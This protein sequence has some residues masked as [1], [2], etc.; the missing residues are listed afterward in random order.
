MY[1]LYFFAHCYLLFTVAFIFLSVINSF[2][3]KD[4]IIK[5]IKKQKKYNKIKHKKNNHKKRLHQRRIKI[6]KP[7]IMSC[8]MVNNSYNIVIDEEI[9]FHDLQ[10]DASI[11]S[12]YQILKI[13][14]LKHYGKNRTAYLKF[15]Y[16]NGFVIIYTSLLK[17][18]DIDHY[19]YQDSFEIIST[20]RSNLN[21]ILKYFTQFIYQEPKIKQPIKYKSSYS[22]LLKKNITYLGKILPKEKSGI[23]LSSV[24]YLKNLNI[25]HYRHRYATIQIFHTFNTNKLIFTIKTFDIQNIN[26]IYQDIYNFLNLS[27]LNSKVL[28]LDK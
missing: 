19:Q 4:I 7:Y 24:S 16:N 26:Y 14:K 10:L 13:E 17:N 3:Q 2:K 12:K 20:S 1:F 6:N 18:K 25:Y 28:K 5:P 8:Y 27:F 23:K 15:Y 9:D 21:R 22:I 11:I